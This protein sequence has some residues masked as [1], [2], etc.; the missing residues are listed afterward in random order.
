VAG[1]GPTLEILKAAAATSA[2]AGEIHFLGFIDDATKIDL[3]SRSELLVI[4]SRREG[5]P[6]VVAEGMA[7]GL[8]TATVDYPDNGTKAVVR[9]YQIGIVSE[10][11]PQALAD[12]AGRILADWKH[13]SERCLEHAPELDWSLLVAKLLS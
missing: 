4:P 7:S 9:Q 5:F 12:A 2:Y 1:A 11:T 6:R 13:Y 10:P 3:L 8:P